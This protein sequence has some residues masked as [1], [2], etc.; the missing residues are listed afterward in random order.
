MRTGQK[1]HCGGLSGSP[2][3][4]RLNEKRGI[5]P[6]PS[7]VRES[8][9]GCLGGS[10]TP[11]LAPGGTTPPPPLAQAE[12]KGKRA[13]ESGRA[14]LN[15]VVRLGHAPQGKN[16]AGMAAGVQCRLRSL[17]GARLWLGLGT[18]WSSTSPA[19]GVT[20]R[21]FFFLSPPF[22]LHPPF[23]QSSLTQRPPTRAPRALR[24]AQKNNPAGCLCRH[25]KIASV[26]SAE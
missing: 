1:R 21:Q 25:R 4:A 12:S 23:L 3:A 22:L 5:A 17:G 26:E 24:S 20:A 15:P 18:G 6:L 14:D 10:G 11:R 19:T 16:R 2:G 7:A 8:R 9:G 13:A